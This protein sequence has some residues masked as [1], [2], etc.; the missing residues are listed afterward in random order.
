MKNKILLLIPALLLTSCGNSAD[1]LYKKIVEYDASGK[2]T[3]T[4]EFTYKGR[5]ILTLKETNDKGSSLLTYTYD[6]DLTVNLKIQKMKDGKYVD[7]YLTSFTYDDNKTMLSSEDFTFNEETSHYEL[8]GITTYEFDENGR[9]SKIRSINYY[10]DL[11]VYMQTEIRYEYNIEGLVSKIDEYIYDDE[12][13]EMTYFSGDIYT[14]ESDNKTIKQIKTLDSDHETLM[15]SNYIYN[16]DMTVKEIDTTKV[17]EGVEAPLKVETFEYDS[18]KNR[19]MLM[20]VYSDNGFG[21]EVVRSEYDK[22]NRLV[23]QSYYDLEGDNEIL[24]S[25]QVYT[26]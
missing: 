26:Y 18:N 11:S 10:E 2:V 15:T 8:T 9:D 13:G 3:L 21:D 12:L 1:D 7:N 5:N 17:T 14:Y 19:T 4:S 25:Y 20:T 16:E 6:G 24:N 22:K 23:K